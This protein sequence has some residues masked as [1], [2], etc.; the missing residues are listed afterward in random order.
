MKFSFEDRQKIN[1]LI[2]EFD[3]NIDDFTFLVWGE[4]IKSV[5]KHEPCEYCGKWINYHYCPE[6][7][8]DL[9]TLN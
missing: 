8:F 4:A 1:D 2:E 9:S 6:C 3:D 5:S 7:G